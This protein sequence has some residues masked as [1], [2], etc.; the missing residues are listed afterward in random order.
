MTFPK[1]LPGSVV[2]WNTIETMRRF[3]VIK[4][5]L[6]RLITD[7]HFRNVSEA[8]QQSQQYCKLSLLKFDC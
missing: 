1:R 3:F 8:K 6:M 4:K 2:L 5:W 7:R